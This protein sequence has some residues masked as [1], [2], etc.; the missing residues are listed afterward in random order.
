MRRKKHSVG[1]IRGKSLTSENNIRNRNTVVNI[2]RGKTVYQ[3][4]HPRFMGPP[5]PATPAPPEYVS[6]Y[7]SFETM[8]VP[9]GIPTSLS[10]GN[11]PYSLRS[12]EYSTITPQDS[13]LA[14]RSDECKEQEESNQYPNIE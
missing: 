12:Q 4:R 10:L 7:P 14:E 9:R 11:L 5:P 6:Q 2:F 13:P 3:N 8:E 1:T